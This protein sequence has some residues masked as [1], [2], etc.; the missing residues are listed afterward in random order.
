M[1]EKDDL[2]QRNLEERQCSLL[3]SSFTLT[4]EEC[5]KVRQI[6]HNTA[7]RHLRVAVSLRDF[8]ENSDGKEFWKYVLPSKT[9]QNQK[10]FDEAWRAVYGED[11]QTQQD[12]ASRLQRILSKCWILAAR[13]HGGL[14]QAW[15]VLPKVVH[16]W[17]S[18]G[19]IGDISGEA[20]EDVAFLRLLMAN[21]TIERQEY[22]WLV[23]WLATR[24]MP[25]AV[26]QLPE[27]MRTP[28]QQL[29]DECSKRFD[30]SAWVDWYLWMPQGSDAEFGVGFDSFPKQDGAWQDY[31]LDG[32]P[33][34]IVSTQ[35]T[36]FEAV[37][38]SRGVDVDYISRSAN[39]KAQDWNTMGDKNSGCVL[40]PRSDIPFGVF[41][42]HRNGQHDDRCN[43]WR[44]GD[45]WWDDNYC[46]PKLRWNQNDILV[47]ARTRE[48]LGKV[49]V[50]APQ[51]QVKETHVRPQR[52]VYHAPE[53][54]L[55]E[56]CQVFVRIFSINDRPADQE[57][58]LEFWH[59]EKT[60]CRI[61]ILPKTPVPEI[62]QGNPDGMVLAHPNEEMVLAFS[63][64]PIHL[65]VQNPLLGH[66]YQW[67]ITLDQKIDP[68]W[69]GEGTDFSLR[70]GD[71]LEIDDLSI[72]T[73]KAE[74]R[75]DGSK[76]GRNINGVLLPATVYGSLSSGTNQY[77][78]NWHATIPEASVRDW[79]DGMRRME[80]QGP[81]GSFFIRIPD[82][83]A[84]WWFECG[85][86]SYEQEGG[87]WADS[88]GQRFFS[89][90]DF[91]HLAEKDY[92]TLNLC[93][94]LPCGLPADFP[95]RDKWSN[96]RGYWRCPVWH[97]ISRPEEQA[98]YCYAPEA[99]ERVWTLQGIHIFQYTMPLP[100]HTRFCHD[101]RH[102]LGVFVAEQDQAKTWEVY[103]FSDKTP[104]LFLNGKYMGT[105]RPDE[106][107]LDVQTQWD[108][109]CEEVRGS[110]ALLALME[111]TE[112]DT[113]GISRFREFFW[114]EEEQCGEVRCI[115]CLTDSPV[116]YGED[117]L[118]CAKRAK[119]WGRDLPPNHPLRKMRFFITPQKTTLEQIKK[120]W[121][122]QVQDLCHCPKGQQE[123]AWE[124]LI[125]EWSASG[126]HPLLEGIIK[127]LK[128]ESKESFLNFPPPPPQEYPKIDRHRWPDFVRWWW[129]ENEQGG[130]SSEGYSQKLRHLGF[131]RST[132][133][134]QNSIKE[135]L[136]S[137]KERHSK[138]FS[139]RFAIDTDEQFKSPE[140]EFQFFGMFEEC[141]IHELP[142]RIADEKVCNAMNGRERS[143]ETGNHALP[144]SAEPHP[145]PVE[146]LASIRLPLPK[147]PR[148]ELLVQILANMVQQQ[149]APTDSEWRFCLAAAICLANEVQIPISDDFQ[150]IFVQI[151]ARANDNPNEKKALNR[152]YKIC[153]ASVQLPKI[154][155]KLDCME[156]FSG[157]GRRSSIQPEFGRRSFAIT[158]FLQQSLGSNL[159]LPEE[160][161]RA[162]RPQDDTSRQYKV[163][164]LRHL[165]N[166]GPW[167]TGPQGPNDREW[168]LSWAA[169]ECLLSH[170]KGI[171]I[172]AL[173][174]TVLERIFD[175]VSTYYRDVMLNDC[176]DFQRLIASSNP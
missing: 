89:P 31:K 16:D 132:P 29:F 176:D 158:H 141:G 4:E 52:F 123:S 94:C 83:Q 46:A 121:R 102:H 13:K 142:S 105:T 21:D 33:K 69:R 44:E 11:G 54:Q 111:K 30:P 112:N 159:P 109:F 75:Q 72:H 160:I 85:I 170:L 62:S 125:A 15:K 110:D 5:A 138:L 169:T 79:V 22:L 126:F 86:R 23:E 47:C 139:G 24:E 66:E 116:P 37:P 41:L 155:F 168:I 14:S 40:F 103:A 35:G 157:P 78:A 97:L 117:M 64:Q 20:R 173:H 145:L 88:H 87:L 48:D 135:F 93:I 82:N 39:D 115:T 166:I 113:D 131:G 107:F 129:K 74:C 76:I 3:M 68:A 70:L 152:Y 65:K 108:A 57:S 167:S 146:L 80:L 154:R 130:P 165:Q 53:G 124:A 43:W 175:F 56:E 101:A 38:L 150:R 84:H 99:N 6:P 153:Q 61:T 9:P 26:G 55:E 7:H 63:E 73:W 162:I 19:V 104:D 118:H 164:F 2:F 10:W 133:K 28:F 51:V 27:E 100:S 12:D 96:P 49:R 163:L 8:F 98:D 32:K 147:D 106:R 148:K 77:P 119:S 144:F 120:E 136:S 172:S 71:L 92:S 67:T 151:L 128:E 91:P 134:I 58:D 17:Q 90:G 42:R 174:Q 114:R 18:E 81:N 34:R 143:F 156:R 25:D 60:F 122:E 171:E 127:T 140:E 36:W 45:R 50:M 137:Y 59:E 161:L 149:E 1:S 95:Q